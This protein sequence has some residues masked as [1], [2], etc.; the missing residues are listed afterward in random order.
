MRMV[1]GC[2]FTLLIGLMP[3]FQARA[4]SCSGASHIGCSEGIDQSGR[5]PGGLYNAAVEG[6]KEARTPGERALARRAMRDA[7][8]PK[9]SNQRA[10]ECNGNPGTDRDFFACVA[11]IG[12]APGMRMTVSCQ[13]N[14]SDGRVLMDGR[15]L[16][17]GAHYKVVRYQPAS[18]DD[19]WSHGSCDVEFT[20]K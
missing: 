14:L 6:L 5:S 12:P 17:A 19:G 16:P 11:G 2:L 18:T 3:G 15:V 7:F 9:M 10:V 13:Q 8:D 20:H 4:V 1:A